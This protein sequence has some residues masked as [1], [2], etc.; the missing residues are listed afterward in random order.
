M[1]YEDIVRSEKSNDNG[2]HYQLDHIS[3]CNWSKKCIHHNTTHNTVHKYE[4]KYR[5]MFGICC[6]AYRHHYEGIAEISDLYFM[7]FILLTKLHYQADIVDY[8]LFYFM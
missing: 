8:M 4:T 2:F 1:Y 5:R 7:R 3:Q 6:L